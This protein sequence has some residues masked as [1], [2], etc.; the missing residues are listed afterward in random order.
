MK[1][2]AKRI[3]RKTWPFGLGSALPLCLVAL[4]TSEPHEVLFTLWV[5][6]VIGYACGWSDALAKTGETG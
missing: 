3:W 4:I 6:L 5:G 2:A 1:N